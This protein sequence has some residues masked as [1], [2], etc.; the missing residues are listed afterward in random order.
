M[1]KIVD[2][3]IILGVYAITNVVVF[4]LFAYDKR[5]AQKN[6][7][8]IPENQLLFCAL[9]GPFGAYAAMLVFRHKTRKLKF[10]LIPV[11]TLLH[12]ALLIGFFYFFM[13]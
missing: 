7:W 9:I 11:V 10:Y 13:H 8:R 12:L 2:I 3:C 1:V 4:S 5:K 6:A